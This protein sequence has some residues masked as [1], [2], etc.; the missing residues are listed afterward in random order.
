MEAYGC[1][2]DDK[3]WELGGKQRVTTSPGYKIPLNFDKGL[4]YM[5]VQPY[6]DDDWDRYDHFMLTDG[7]IPWNSALNG[8]EPI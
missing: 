3:A 5:E 1:E 7:N 4:P 8:I 2:C 6:T